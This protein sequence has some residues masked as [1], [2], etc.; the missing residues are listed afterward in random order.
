M[1]AKDRPA[2]GGNPPPNQC[3]GIE[4][5][6]RMVDVGAEVIVSEVGGADLGGF[7]SPHDLAARVFSAMESAKG[8]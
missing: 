1:T 6:P 2:L 4:A 8:R 5:T 3:E 7:F